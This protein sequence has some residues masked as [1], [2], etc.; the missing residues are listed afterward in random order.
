M[1]YFQDKNNV[2]QVFGTK[3]WIKNQEKAE[4]SSF[5]AIFKWHGRASLCTDRAS[6]FDQTLPINCECHARTVRISRT[7]VQPFRS[8]I[9]AF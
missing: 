2:E 9:L 6:L 8:P 3:A 7:T 1:F 5:H 4:K